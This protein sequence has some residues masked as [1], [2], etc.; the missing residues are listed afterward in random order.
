MDDELDDGACSLSDAALVHAAKRRIDR[1]AEALKTRPL[2]EHALGEM[3]QL[4]GEPVRSAQA[5][6]RRLSAATGTAVTSPTVPATEIP[7]IDAGGAL[8]T[9]GEAPLPQFDSARRCTSWA[10]GEVA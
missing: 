5:A 10:T 4:L 1:A 7:T 9:P 2:D 8:P 6:L 3:R